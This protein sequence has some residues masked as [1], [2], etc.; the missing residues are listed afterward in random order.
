MFLSDVDSVWIKFVDLDK[1]PENFDAFN[2]IAKTH[3][4]QIYETWGFTLCGGLGGYRASEKMIDFFEKLKLK[5]Q[6]ECDD[7]TAH[8]VKKRLNK[9]RKP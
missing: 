7:Q 8:S 3:P 2:A 6:V 5:C 1:L 9:V 4:K